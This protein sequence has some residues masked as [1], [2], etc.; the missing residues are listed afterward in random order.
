MEPLDGIRHETAASNMAEAYGK[1][2]G[3]PGLCFVTHA[4]TSQ[5]TVAV[6][7]AAIVGGLTEWLAPDTGFG[8]VIRRCCDGRGKSLKSSYER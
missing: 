3:M 2:T 6:D 8:G 7:M 5:A 1:P 4:S